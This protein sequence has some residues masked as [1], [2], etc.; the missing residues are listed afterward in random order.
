MKRHVGMFL[1]EPPHV[2]VG[3]QGEI[4]LLLIFVIRHAH[5]GR[6]GPYLNIVACLT[7]WPSSKEMIS[8]LVCL[9][10]DAS[11]MDTDG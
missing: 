6:H 8:S 5:A 10:K 3:E 11:L 9:V 2:S 4:R 1:H 7:L